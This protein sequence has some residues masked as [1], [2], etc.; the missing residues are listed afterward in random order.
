MIPDT[1]GQRVQPNDGRVHQES[2][3]GGYETPS[4]SLLRKVLRQFYEHPEDDGH[5]G[6]P[7]EQPH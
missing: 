1:S 5:K 3:I 6:Y 2:E 4:S 7:Q